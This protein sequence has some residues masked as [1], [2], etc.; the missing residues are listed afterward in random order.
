MS[1]HLNAVMTQQKKQA[2]Y[3]LVNDDQGLA[4]LC[5]TL[6]DSEWLAVDTEFEREKTYFPELCLVQL[7]DGRDVAIVDPISIDN[8]SPLK[9]LLYKASITKIFHAARQDLEIFYFLWGSLPANIFDTQIAAPLLGYDEQAGYGKLVQNMLGVSLEKAHTR[10]NWKKR[11]LSK[12]QLQYAADDVI[13]LAKLYPLIRDSLENCGR[14]DWLGAEL[15]N[16]SDPALYQLDPEQY[17]KRIKNT[18]KLNSTKRSLLKKLV[19]WREEVARDENKPRNWILRDEALLDIASLSP[20][21]KSDLGSL[22]ALKSGDIG[23]HSES[24]LQLCRSA[25]AEPVESSPAKHEQRSLTAE[26]KTLR[27]ALSVVVSVIAI[28]NQLNPKVLAPQKEL[29]KFI[30]KQKPCLLTAGWRKELL[31]EVLTQFMHGNSA[32]II[33]S[34]MPEIKKM[35]N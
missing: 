22:K 17:L 32:L 1:L 5:N 4:D 24:I 14:K 30:L 29:E 33:N 34:G 7:S 6:R 12:D 35:K 10:T 28:Q 19:S 26:E 21:E 27:D 23:R 8:L 25:Q 2:N 31:E 13:Y 9:E 16:L 18:R 15:D 3:S 11:P 20:R